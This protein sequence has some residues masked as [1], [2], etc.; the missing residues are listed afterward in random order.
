MC[1]SITRV[2]FHQ[3]GL[4]PKLQKAIQT[5]FVNFVKCFDLQKDPAFGGLNWITVTLRIQIT[6][7]LLQFSVFQ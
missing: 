7:F 2:Q 3:F 1:T 5:I 6:V 4:L